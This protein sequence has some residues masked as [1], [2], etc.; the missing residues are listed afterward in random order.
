M[1]RF[2]IQVARVTTASMPPWI[3]PDCGMTIVPVTEAPLDELTLVAFPGPCPCP[4]RGPLQLGRDS[5]RSDARQ[6]WWVC[7][8]CGLGHPVRYRA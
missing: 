4:L 5:R 6:R 8:G 7:A 1:L 2:Q 3:C